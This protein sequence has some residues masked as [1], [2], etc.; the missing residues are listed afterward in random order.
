MSLKENK[1][2][3]I[4]QMVAKVRRDCGIRTDISDE[5]FLSDCIEKTRRH[6][7]LRFR[8]LNDAERLL[9]ESARSSV[10]AGVMWALDV[11]KA[12]PNARFHG[13]TALDIALANNSSDHTVE[14]LREH[15]VTESTK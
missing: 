6:G 11:E 2:P 9:F 13:S 14:I 5:E 8:S 15:G 1:A 4:K 10:D 12:N 7:E 3:E